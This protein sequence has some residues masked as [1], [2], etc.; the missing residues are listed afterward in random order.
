[1]SMSSSIRTLLDFLLRRSRVEREMEEEL[2]L[3]LR[4]RADDL[5]RQGLPRAEA[6][7]QASM[8]F[9]GYQRYKEECREALGARLLGE[10]IADGRYGLRQLRRNPGFTAV[11]I[12]TLALGIGANS[13]IFSVVNGVLLNPL[14]YPQPDQL[15][16]LHESKPNFPTGS[17]SYPNFLDWQRENH[18]F[19]SMAVARHDSFTLTGVG[20][21]EQVSAEF[22]SSNFFSLLGV[23]PVVGRT[24]TPEEDR[25]GA[26]PVAL[27][28]E[29][30]WKR[31]FGSAQDVV[32][33]SITL[34][35]NGFTVVGVIPAS[36]DLLLQAF[37]VKDVYV[38][39]MQWDNSLLTD[40]SAGLSIHG[41]GRL[42]PGVTVEQARADMAV[43]TRNL[44][45]AYPD[46]NKGISATIVP[47]KQEMVGDIRPYLLVLLAAVGFVLLIAC[48]NVANLLLARSTGRTQEFAIRAA[49]G[50][51]QGRVIRQLLTESVLLAMAGGGLG[52]LLASWGTRAAL[53]VL[54]TALPRAQ[55][56]GLDTRVLTFTALVSL[57]AGIF[58]GLAPALKTSK[59]DLHETLKEGGRGASG[60][61]HR[62]HGV[63]VAVEMAMAVVLLIG[64]GLMIRSLARLW[65]VNPGFDPQCVLTFDVS[66]PPSM[67]T[68]SPS[69]VRA[70]F[71]AVDDK[72]EST[73]GVQAASLSWGALPM[74]GD[75][76]EQLF[77]P[78][79]QPKPSS[80]NDMKWAL[81]YIVEPHYLKVMG[82][83]LERG[84]FFTSQDRDHS[85]PVIVVDDEFVRKF[86]PN[87][88]PIGKRV[89]LATNPLAG[90]AEIVGVVRHVNQWGL[91]SD[92]TN[93][94]RAEMYLSFLQMPD[95]QFSGPS[96]ATA[97]VRFTGADLTVIHSIRHVIHKMNAEEV[98]Y[99]F[100]TMDQIIEASL[101]ARR[102]SMMLL[103]AFAALALVLAS[104]GIYGVISY[105]A[106]Q[107]THEIG[108]RIALGAQRADILL[109]VIGQGAQ[110]VLAGVVIG[111]V[112]AFGLTRVMAKYSLLFGV[113]ATDPLTFIAVSLILTGVALAACY[114][115]ARRATKV[116]PMVALRYE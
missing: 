103:G 52:L 108:V 45:A 5:E 43:I 25:K 35:G 91:D 81:R 28:S 58:F 18:T 88:D 13:A 20:D 115:P 6:E 11:A 56:I 85:P 99:G 105:L 59:P 7:R 75:D 68:A 57:L 80:E 93:P 89:N 16:T 79:G 114:I 24:F 65:S 29:G 106:T 90:N 64:A 102:F 70:A 49:L 53:G 97:V 72:L 12:I 15:V 34:D 87:Q 2:R 48:V 100:R 63:F 22:I 38:P 23:K 39:I 31:K 112:A 77:W 60:A 44:A 73:P 92:S 98:V 17:I 55:E 42:K 96:G 19:S 66:L 40:R 61:R 83:S 4:S 37:S 33:K 116:D 62:V 69:A 94:L 41:I 3:H 10:L 111:L 67:N 82:V 86:F 21:A 54:P 74:S 8:E 1:M 30:L 107:R 104:L 76:D 110:M 50:A 84:R 47:L 9:G 109:L 36:F 101:A 27:I 51:G 14:P 32:G 95:S 46:A 26:G 71:R 113:S 78:E